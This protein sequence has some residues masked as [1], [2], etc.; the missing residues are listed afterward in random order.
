[1]AGRR[2]KTNEYSKRG[3]LSC[4]RSHVKCD[5]Q[6]PRC[7]RCT[8]RNTTCEY[9]KTF[10]N[11]TVEIRNKESSPMNKELTFESSSFSSSPRNVIL[12]NSKSPSMLSPSEEAQKQSLPSLDEPRYPEQI[13][14]ISGTNCNKLG[15]SSDDPIPIYLD[16]H[17]IEDCKIASV[18]LPNFFKFELSLENGT[19]INFITTIAKKDAL[20]S[21]HSTNF[22]NQE[23]VDFIWTMCRI[24]KFFFIFSLFPKDYILHIESILFQLISNFPILQTMI[25]Y[26]ASSHM[27]RLYKIAGYEK[28]FTM[29]RQVEVVSF[30]QCIEYLK[31]RL[32]SATTFVEHVVLT[33]NVVII[34][35]GN[36]SNSSGH[37]HLSGCYELI[38]KCYKLLPNVSKCTTLELIGLELFT[39]IIDW[40]KHTSLM[41]MISSQKRF[42]KVELPPSIPEIYKRLKI[43][44]NDVDFVSGN[45]KQLDY[46][47]TL[48]CQEMQLLESK[49]IYFSG[50]SCVYFAVTKHISK[51]LED[52]QEKGLMLLQT[53]SR[54]QN[55]FT[56]KRLESNDFELDLTLKM[57]NLMSFQGLYLYLRFFFMG[58]RDPLKIR[59]LLRDLLDSCYS[60]PYKSSCAILRHW[61]L[62]I[63]ALIALI[64]NE[65]IIYEKIIEIFKLF[66]ANGM[67][68][69]SIC[70]LEDVRQIL[71]KQTYDDLLS[72]EYNVVIC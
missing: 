18:Q 35:L 66:L 63:A 34:Y 57:C 70:I 9:L 15:I 14:E 13:S 68:V 3:C 44:Q 30:H 12:Q 54:I 27:A 53:L 6:L 62:Y 61:V 24:T 38:N 26:H 51:T 50:L 45:A 41:A 56:Y 2:K 37:M 31:T 71:E 43:S 59:S 5:E 47:I 42:S 65:A 7:S 4:K 20:L 48:M 58:E 16:C 64:Q 69:H 40:Y 21:T 25:T 55:Q 8:R 39:F 67:E 11:C 32:E 36:V 29:W 28:A 1:M 23:F 33:F 72:S 19:L 52:A 60:M 10:K 22:N 46:F 17:N 49:G